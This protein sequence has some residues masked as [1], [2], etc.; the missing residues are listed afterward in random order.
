MTKEKFYKRLIACFA[1]MLV[2]F[3]LFGGAASG[4]DKAFYERGSW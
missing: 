4:Q 1:L 3:A 2:F